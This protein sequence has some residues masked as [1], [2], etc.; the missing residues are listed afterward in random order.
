MTTVMGR[1]TALINGAMA[2]SIEV[3]QPEVIPMWSMDFTQPLY[4]RRREP[5]ELRIAL[6]L[7]TDDLDS[8]DALARWYQMFETMGR[9]TA[10]GP[11]RVC[12]YCGDYNPAGLTKC[13]HCGGETQVQDFVTAWRFP[14]VLTSISDLST[15]DR[16]NEPITLDIEMRAVD[17][18]TTQDLEILYQPSP[19][20]RLETLP[21]NCILNPDLY[22]CQYCG[23]VVEDGKQCPNCGGQRLPWSELVKMDH[24][25]LYCG[26]KVTGGIVC[27]GCAASISGQALRSVLQ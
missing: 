3:S 1:N 21:N 11:G 18:V 4:V 26:C 19:N 17:A 20:V 24:R 15:T 7:F 27:P 5:I 22:L 9:L 23:T 12:P 8:M 14:F 10:L 13:W 2:H 25:C 16:F 6:M